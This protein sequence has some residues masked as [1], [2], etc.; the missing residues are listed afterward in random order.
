MNTT[1]EKQIKKISTDFHG[2]LMINGKNLIKLQS[3]RC[4]SRTNAS[5]YE[6]IPKLDVPEKEIS[7]ISE[8]LGRNLEKNSWLVS[9]FQKKQNLKQIHSDQEE[10]YDNP[11]L[12][13]LA[14]PTSLPEIKEKR[15][16]KK[17]RLVQINPK[18]P[19]LMKN[20]KMNNDLYS[21]YI[22]LLQV[23]NGFEVQK[24][25]KDLKDF[26]GPGNNDSL[27]SKIMKKKPGWV[28]VYAY[29]S[30]NFI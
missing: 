13:I 29:H 17:H 12:Q 25:N 15:I 10:N 11:C 3:I 19:V 23:S 28:R 18:K 27:I 2:P 24:T 9:A 14:A 20:S 22:S 4:Y 30:A 5:S 21:K 16:P 7:F 26:I 8:I 6:K 1:F